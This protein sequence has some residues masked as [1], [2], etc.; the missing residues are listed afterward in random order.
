MTELMWLRAVLTEKFRAVGP[1]IKK[2][3]RSQIDNLTLHLKKLGA[4]GAGLTQY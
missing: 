4:G 1:Y 2:E 3:E